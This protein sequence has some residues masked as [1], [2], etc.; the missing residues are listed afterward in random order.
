MQ[1]LFIFT[2]H[3]GRTWAIKLILGE[4]QKATNSKNLE[5]AGI[6]RLVSLI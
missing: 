5:L 6:I 4:L 2:E 1:S 3:R